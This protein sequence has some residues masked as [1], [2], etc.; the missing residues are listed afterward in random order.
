MLADDRKQLF[1]GVCSLLGMLLIPFFMGL[2][3]YLERFDIVLMLLVGLALVVCQFSLITNGTVSDF[4]LRVTIAYFVIVLLYN[5][6]FDP[7]VS[8]VL[9]FLLL[10]LI[11]PFVLGRREGSV[12]SVSF[13]IVGA[14]ALFMSHKEVWT[15]M[16]TF[17]DFVVVYLLIAITA[18]AYE[19]F[20]INSKHDACK[21]REHLNS[22]ISARVA[23]N[24]DKQQ[25][26]EELQAAMRDIQGLSGLVPICAIC[27]SIRD[28]AGYWEQLE[29]Y[30]NRNSHLRQ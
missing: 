25:L 14:I 13:L 10:P 24:A 19:T 28:D 23:A 4:L 27:K 29:T 8:S 1:V 21:R 26:I 12:W 17:A 16:N 22:E 20:R 7:K 18:F 5:V 15:T 6:L 3:Y 9:F 11:L 2:N 30:L